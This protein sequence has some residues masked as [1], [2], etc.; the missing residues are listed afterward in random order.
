MSETT[1]LESEYPS[2]MRDAAVRLIAVEESYA[3]LLADSENVS[4]WKNCDF[5]AL[6][7][8]KICELML[9]GSTVAH[10]REGSADVDP[11]KWRPKE[12]FGELAKHSDHPLQVPIE[13]KLHED[14]SGHHAVPISTGL[15]FSTLNTIYGLCGDMLHVPSAKKVVTSSI[16]PFNAGLYKSWIDGFRRL[17]LGHALLLPG[18]KLILL[19]TWSGSI[20][21]PPAVYL[22]SALGDSTLDWS[23]YPEFTLLK[24]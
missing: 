23:K 22:L 6:Q 17:L 19:C 13:L 5:I 15:P 16:P 10:L 20:N 21:E 4:A 7:I 18:L 12:A 14:G 3:E 1:E 2:V 11:K 8:R 9:L 24:A